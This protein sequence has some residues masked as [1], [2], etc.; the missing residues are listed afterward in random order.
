MLATGNQER[1]AAMID[2]DPDFFKALEQLDAKEKAYHRQ[3]VKTGNTKKQS[4][5]LKMPGSDL[6]KRE[7]DQ[8]AELQKFLTI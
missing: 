7:F 3:Q 8:I 4:K 1:L 6:S 2:A 5:H